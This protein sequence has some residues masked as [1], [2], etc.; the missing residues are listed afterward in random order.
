MT[1]VQE[2]RRTCVITMTSDTASDVIRVCEPECRDAV[3]TDLGLLGHGGGW[4][5]QSRGQANVTVAWNH[6]DYQVTWR[7]RPP[8][9]MPCDACGDEWRTRSAR[10]RVSLPPSEAQ[11]ASRARFAAEF[12]RRPG[13]STAVA[14]ETDAGSQDEGPGARPGIFRWRRRPGPVRNP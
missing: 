12:G 14:V 1:E 3:L 8:S 13:K 5:F 9:A 6:K 10:V 11:L 7:R 2:T 4:A